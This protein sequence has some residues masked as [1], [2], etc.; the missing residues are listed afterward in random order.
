MRDVP[1]PLLQRADC[2]RA[3]PRPLGQL[4]LGQPGAQAMLLEEGAEPGR[5]LRCDG[6]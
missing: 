2:P 6:A 1:T 5:L 4:L 3:Q